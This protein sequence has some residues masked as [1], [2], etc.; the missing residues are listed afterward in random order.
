MPAPS[1]EGLPEGTSD[2]MKANILLL[3]EFLGGSI[4]GTVLAPPCWAQHVLRLIFQSL[5][6]CGECSAA[7]QK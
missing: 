2:A 4:G 1:L 6:G 7:T 3:R 5:T